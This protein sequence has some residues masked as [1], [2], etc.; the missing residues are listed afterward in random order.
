MINPKEITD[1]NLD[2]WH[3]EEHILFWVAAAG[4]NGITA[5]RCVYKFLRSIGAMEPVT[6]FQAIYAWAHSDAVNPKVNSSLPDMMKKAG[7]GCYNSK[8]QTFAELALSDINLRTCTVSDLESI[9]GIGKKTSRCFLLH[10]RENARVAGLDVHMLKHLK[11]LG[12]KVPKSTPTG[13]RYLTLEKIVLML[14]DEA[15]MTPAEYDLHVWTQHNVVSKI[16]ESFWGWNEGPFVSILDQEAVA[17]GVI[18][19]EL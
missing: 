3:L 14:A 2:D 19:K 17:I 9:H 16:P 18:N 7:I 8:A 6:P 12:H 4:K 5:S 10:S 13:K 15:G 11:A 1:F